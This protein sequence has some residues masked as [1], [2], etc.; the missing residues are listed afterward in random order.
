ME[1][2]QYSC[3]N[4]GT[5]RKNPSY[6]Q[7]QNVWLYSSFMGPII[8]NTKLFFIYGNISLSKNDV[9]LGGQDF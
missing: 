9:G 8:I 5:I 3:D 6:S 4:C 2:K 7:S 1:M